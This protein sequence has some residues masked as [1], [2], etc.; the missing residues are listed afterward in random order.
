ISLPSLEGRR[1]LTSSAT[2]NMEHSMCKSQ[3]CH[4]AAAQRFDK[5]VVGRR[6]EGHGGFVVR[7]KRTHITKKENIVLGE[8]A[9][10]TGGASG[11]LSIVAMTLLAQH[12]AI[13]LVYYTRAYQTATS[14]HVV[15]KDN[16]G[17]LGDRVHVFAYR[18]SQAMGHPRVMRLLRGPRSACLARSRARSHCSKSTEMM[19]YSTVGTK[20]TTLGIVM[21]V[22]E[23]DALVCN[24]CSEEEE[25]LQ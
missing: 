5:A 16:F 3:Q 7:H 11:L 13:G 12:G 2:S 25:G 9:L 23:S 18:P 21:A 19:S 1:H 6:S 15:L 4:A 8:G 20:F 24:S 22:C 10:V 17:V 14:S